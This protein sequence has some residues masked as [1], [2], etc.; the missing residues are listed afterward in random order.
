MESFRFSSAVQKIVVADPDGGAPPSVLYLRKEKRKKGS[1]GLRT[2]GKAVHGAFDAQQKF[3][4]TY[5][6]AHD[7]SDAEN[8]DGWLLD[9]PNNLSRAARKALKKLIKQL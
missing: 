4:E 6:A 5:E 8:K 7:R 1:P 9:L 2:L 3:S